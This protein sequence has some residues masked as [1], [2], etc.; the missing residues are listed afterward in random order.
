MTYAFRSVTAALLLVLPCSALVSGE[1]QLID[2][3]WMREKAPKPAQPAAPMEAPRGN[4][5]QLIDDFWMR[6]KAP[7]P[8]QP[9]TPVEAPRKN[10]NQLIDDFWMR[11]KAPRQ[12]APSRPPVEPRPTPAPPAEAPAVPPPS[13][14]A[15]QPQRPAAP[16]TPAPAGQPAGPAETTAAPTSPPADGRIRPDDRISVLVH[17][18]DALSTTG[19]VTGEGRIEMP[20]IGPIEVGGLTTEQAEDRIEEALGRDYLQNPRVEVQIQGQGPPEASGPE[21]GPS[22]EGAPETVSPSPAGR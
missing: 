6:E 11:E 9:A 13:S 7:K 22:P 17:Q 1:N 19:V 16:D 12:A 2:D 14:V 10:K 18:V 3:F 5:N 15:P 8:A 4:K 20:L 21:Q